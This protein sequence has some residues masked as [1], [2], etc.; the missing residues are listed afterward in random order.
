[1]AL[2]LWRVVS[3]GDGD[4]GG[5]LYM[6]DAGW[7]LGGLTTAYQA[8]KAVPPTH[9]TQTIL[10]PVGMRAGLA[11][12]ATTGLCHGLNRGINRLA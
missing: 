10:C 3:S 12:Y 11:F 2:L 7:E 4:G 1:M 8:V 9:P 5:E 6:G